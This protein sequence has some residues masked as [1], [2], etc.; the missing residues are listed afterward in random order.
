MQETPPQGNP[1][2]EK[3]D[4]N[5]VAAK[6]PGALKEALKDGTED[7]YRRKVGQPQVGIKE[8]LALYETDD[9]DCLIG[10]AWLRKGFICVWVGQSGVGKS[11][12][13]MQ[14]VFCWALC[15]PFFGAKPAKGLTSLI[16][17][18]ENDSRDIASEIHGIT[19]GMGF[20]K[21][22]EEVEILNNAIR[23]HRISGKTGKQFLEALEALCLLYKPDMVWIDN[24]FS[25][26]GCDMNDQKAVS[27]FLRAG[28]G[29]ICERTGVAVHIM[30]HT[31]KPPRDPKAG[32]A[33]FLEYAGSGSA[34]ITNMAR[35]TL[36]LTVDKDGGHQ[37]HAS[38]R[39]KNMGLTNP[40][41][42]AADRNK[43]YLKHSPDRIFWL[44]EAPPLDA[45]EITEI[46]NT[47]LLQFLNKEPRTYRTIG[48]EI[49]KKLGISASLATDLVRTAAERHG[50]DKIDPVL[51]K[52]KRCG[53]FTAEINGNMI[54][55]RLKSDSDVD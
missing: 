36:T 51:D 50:L 22:G 33:P 41:G 8:A 12:L 3:V 37:L 48:G 25:Y 34:E 4:A 28:I 45:E 52:I 1:Q 9:K 10:K 6:G 32:Q 20:K 35:C 31:P 7:E 39:G 14:A 21:D 24:L 16:I 27:E 11:A 19:T 47:M 44:Q 43:I 29:G 5:E 13:L 18:S 26:A 46:D 55:L 2:Q 40:D 42:T 53:A 49:H 17:Q 23:I 30:H 38:K 15:R 54:K